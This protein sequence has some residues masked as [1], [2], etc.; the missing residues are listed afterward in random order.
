VLG[1]GSSRRLPQTDP[2][3]LEN[4]S[5]N[6]ENPAKRVSP[7]PFIFATITAL[8]ATIP[9][10]T[11]AETGT[12]G[13]SVGLDPS[14]CNQHDIRQT[15]VYIDDMIL[16][17]DQVGW[18][19][20]IYDKLK[21]TLVPGERV[22]LVEL[23][24]ATGQS[25]EAWSGCWPAYTAEQRAKLS[26]QTYFFNQNP[27]DSIKEQQGYFFHALGV[28]EESIQK[29]GQRPS[30]AVII[31]PDKPPQKSILRAL[32]SDGAR[33]AHSDSTIR[34]IVYSDLAENSDLGSVFKPQPAVPVNYGH[35][36]G[37]Y[38]R[39]SVFYGF[40]VGGDVR[41]G[42][43]VLDTIRS[44]WDD[45]LRSMMANL[46]GLG[47]DLN[48]PN[49]VPVTSQAYNISLTDNGQSL[50]GRLSLLVDSDGELVDSWIGITRLRNASIN[51]IY[52]CTGTVESPGC[53]L[54]AST[55]GGVITTSPV[56]TITLSSHD[57]PTMTGTIGVQGSDANLHLTAVPTSD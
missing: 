47:S 53:T 48:V 27:L 17:D 3:K 25:S 46:G 19:V 26:Q 24:P 49:A 34:A 18:A 14:F 36:L 15:V 2:M 20:T 37:T 43:S 50:V 55:V 1:Q 7:N 4:R 9:F 40:G 45:S 32:A 12:F 56:E 22:S 23:S 21:A 30:S 51:G 16:V 13:G 6:H 29:K 28:A 11:K 10:V 35:K 41:G 38:L 5:L 57:G 33:Y 31:D 44:F 54:Q 8:L 39:R 52:H 42:G